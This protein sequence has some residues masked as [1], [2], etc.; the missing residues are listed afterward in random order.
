MICRKKTAHHWIAKLSL[1]WHVGWSVKFAHVM[2]RDI[3]GARGAVYA[4]PY[5]YI[6]TSVT[7]TLIFAGGKFKTEALLTMDRQSPETSDTSCT[8]RHSLS[9]TA[10]GTGRTQAQTDRQTEKQTNRQ[11][12]THT[13]TETWSFPQKL[14]PGTID[15]LAR[16][17]N[18]RRPLR[19]AAGSLGYTASAC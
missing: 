14:K 18:I 8:H 15:Y 10:T 2:T 3:T 4:R 16:N 12:D 9:D 17:V 13:H 7:L 19:L 1:H 6:I 11:T 5:R